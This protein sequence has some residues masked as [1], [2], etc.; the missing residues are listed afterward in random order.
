MIVRHINDPIPSARALNPKIPPAVDELIR[1]TMAKDAADRPQ[2]ASEFAALLARAAGQ[3]A[4]ALPVG[5]GRAASPTVVVPGGVPPVEAAPTRAPAHGISP[6]VWAV[7]AIVGICLL[8]SLLLGGGG[9]AAVF[10]NRTP[11]PRPTSTLPAVTPT[12]GITPSPVGQLLA[13]NFSNAASGFARRPDQDGGVSYADDTLKIS[14]L[15]KG[16]EFYAPS[17]RLNVED[18]VVRV[19]ILPPSGPPS[20]AVGILCRFVDR[21]NFTAFAIS[22][23]GQYKIWK[24][25]DKVFTRFVD[26]TD[27]PALPDTGGP[28]TLT[29]ACAGTHLTLAVGEITVGQAE[30]PAPIAGDI[31][32]MAGLREAGK[33]AVSFDNLV[34]SQP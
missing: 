13:D 22:G 21:F 18:A 7:A 14:V 15:T 1:R 3:P 5:A 30:D 23:E 6:L 31:G 2:T 29:A 4:E 28:V 34:V 12:A 24:I 26:W 8:G 10:L 19:D 33:L 20:S 27:L 17:N 25:Q 32:F 11:T 16:I 9:L